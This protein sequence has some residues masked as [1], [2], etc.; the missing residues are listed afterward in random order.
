VLAGLF[1]TQFFFTN[2]DIRVAY[3]GMYCALAVLILARDV[4]GMPHFFRAARD[5]ARGQANLEKGEHTRLE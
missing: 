1:G 2:G 5:T 4:P 3:G